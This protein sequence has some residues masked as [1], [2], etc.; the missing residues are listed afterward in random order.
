MSLRVTLIQ[1]R[2][3]CPSRLLSLITE[4]SVFVSLQ[5]TKPESSWLKG[6]RLQNY[7]ENKCEGNENKNIVGDFNINMDKMVRDGGN[8]TQ[9]LYICRSKGP[10]YTGFP[11]I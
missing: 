5:G 4:F 7:M 8:K 1:K 2:D 3:L 11:L 6:E 10:G 9:R